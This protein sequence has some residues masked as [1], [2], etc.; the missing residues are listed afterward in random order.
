M[1]NWHH[2]EWSPDSCDCYLQFVFDSDLPQSQ[3]VNTFFAKL[4]SCSK[5]PNLTGTTI[6]NVVVAENTNVQKLISQVKTITGL[7]TLDN[8]GSSIKSIKFFSGIDSSRLLNFS[9]TGTTLTTNQKNT[10]QSWCDT[11]LGVGKVVIS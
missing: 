10:I 4:K 7:T 6:W 1:V 2:N 3:Q 8:E 9:V 5:H 11:N